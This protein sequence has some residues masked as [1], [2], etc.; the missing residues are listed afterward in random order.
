MLSKKLCKKFG[1]DQG[2]KTLL[3]KDE[4]PVGIKYHLPSEFQLLYL[5]DVI[6]E[7]EQKLV[8]RNAD[9]IIDTEGDVEF[10]QKAIDNDIV[11]I[12]LLNE[13][14]KELAESHPKGKFTFATNTSFEE[15]VLFHMQRFLSGELIKEWENLKV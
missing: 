8:L 2:K 5:S 9:L 14:T 1:L 4:P 11:F 10:I 3:T 12:G 13:E 6:L 7:S 15:N